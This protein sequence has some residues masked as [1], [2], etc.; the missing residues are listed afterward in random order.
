M[1]KMI[2]MMFLLLVTLFLSSCA[3]SNQFN[4]YS[5]REDVSKVEIIHVNTQW[6]LKYEVLNEL[7]ENEVEVFLEKLSEINYTKSLFGD[8]GT[9]DDEKCIKITYK[10]GDFDIVTSYLIVKFDANSSQIQWESIIIDKLIVAE[11]YNVLIEEYG[12]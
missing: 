4:Y 12:E 2:C 8:P 6:E 9:L 11:K 3:K 10:S 5:L 7:S 1:K